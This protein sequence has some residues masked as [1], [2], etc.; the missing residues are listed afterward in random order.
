MSHFYAVNG[1]EGVLKLKKH[2]NEEFDAYI[3]R[4]PPYVQKVM[5]EE[6]EKI[7]PLPF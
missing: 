5:R 2:V 3:L 7:F 1:K 4:L 6:E